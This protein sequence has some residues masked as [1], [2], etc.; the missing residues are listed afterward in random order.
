MGEE[1]AVPPGVCDDALRLDID[2]ICVHVTL[3]D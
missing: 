3:S 2:R 1:A